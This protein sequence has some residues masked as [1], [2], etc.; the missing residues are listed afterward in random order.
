MHLRAL[1][2]ARAS[3]GTPPTAPPPTV[4]PHQTQVQMEAL[5]MGQPVQP[6]A[7][8]DPNTGQPLQPAQPVARFDPNTGRPL[9]PPERNPNKAYV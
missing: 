4:Q 2:R 3:A 1:K 9:Q 6:V 8:F 7:R 5:A